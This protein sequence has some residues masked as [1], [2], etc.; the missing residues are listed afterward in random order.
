MEV[1]LC[2]HSILRSVNS[3]DKRL[4]SCLHTYYNGI[5]KVVSTQNEEI[6]EGRQLY[7]STYYVLF[8]AIVVTV[9]RNSFLVC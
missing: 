5:V 9:P 6:E 2:I 7:E 3:N 8:L 4:V 1:A